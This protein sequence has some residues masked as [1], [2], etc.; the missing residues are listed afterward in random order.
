[1]IST[2]RPELSEKVLYNLK[3]PYPRVAR[4]RGS[5][6]RQAEVREGEGHAP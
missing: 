6:T 1:M 3:G 2:W 5:K 4:D